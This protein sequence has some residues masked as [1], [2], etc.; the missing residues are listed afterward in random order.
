MQFAN[1]LLYALLIGNVTLRVFTNY[2]QVLPKIFNIFDVFVTAAFVVF[3]ILSRRRIVRFKKILYLL[4]GFNCICL[5]GSL[6]NPEYFYPSAA[7]AQLVMY[8][9]PIVLFLVLVNLPITM[10]TIQIFF[11]MLFILVCLQI[12]LGILQVPLYISTGDTEQIIGTF[13]GN[14]EQYGA[15]V[16]L[17]VFLFLSLSLV[18][19]KLKWYFYFLSI[20]SVILII[21]VDNK[22]SWFAIVISM[23]YLATRF[24]ITQKDNI[25]RITT[26]CIIIT[27]ITIAFGI[28]KQSITYGKIEN[29]LRVISEGKM[30]ELGKLSAYR[31]VFQAFED[32]PHMALMG[33]G[34]GNFYSRSSYQFYNYSNYLNKS[35]VQRRFLNQEQ[36]IAEKAQKRERKKSN[37]LGGVIEKANKDPFYA[38]YYDGYKEFYFIGS[39]Q[40][41]NP[42]SSYVA[43]LGETGFLGMLLY[44]LIYLIIIKSIN[45]II[46]SKII[47]NSKIFPLEL[48]ALGMIIY[49]LSVSIYGMWLDTGRI[50]TILWAMIAVIFQYDRS[51]F[52]KTKRVVSNFKKQQKVIEHI[53]ENSIS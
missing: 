30:F 3:F 46:N 40:I 38:Q 16:M 11:K 7:L 20:I 42:F 14:A 9:E 21:L 51:L 48:A 4:V 41:D 26:L 36:I 18:K 10:K 27:L 43:L 44:L 12:T 29:T 1:F 37:S 45:Q 28:A 5:F 47:K 34:L 52:Q 23:V 35:K 31:D 19:P 22:A 2:L 25:H 24:L 32:N 39:G 53:K 8:N 15:F 33:T 6:F 50:N 13:H 49:L 17:G